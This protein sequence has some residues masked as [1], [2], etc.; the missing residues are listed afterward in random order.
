MYNQISDPGR[1]THDTSK[2]GVVIDGARKLYCFSH[3]CLC[4]CVCVCS[5]AFLLRFES[6]Q[7]SKKKKCENTVELVQR[8]ESKISNKI[9]KMI[10]ICLVSKSIESKKTFVHLL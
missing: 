3:I 6:F 8:T 7:E 2:D 1:K 5:T 4:V 10:A 9:N